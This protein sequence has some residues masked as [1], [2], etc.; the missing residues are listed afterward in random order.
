MGSWTH[1]CARP[2][3]SRF[4]RAATQRTSR[5]RRAKREYREIGSLTP[6]PLSSKARK[7]HM[8]AYCDV[9][10]K[11]SQVGKAVGVYKEHVLAYCQEGPGAQSQSAFFLGELRGTGFKAESSQ[12]SDATQLMWLMLMGRRVNKKAA[13]RTASACS[14][15]RC[16]RLAGPLG[17]NH[18][19]YLHLPAI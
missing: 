13:T 15:L 11:E 12:H 6:P 9:E 3:R 8:F 18:K 7:E 4:S 17:D 16:K 2:A 1:P 5:A 14:A 10:D 19:K